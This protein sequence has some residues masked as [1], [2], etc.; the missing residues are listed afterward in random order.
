MMVFTGSGITKMV[1]RCVRCGGSV[2]IES[3][4][5]YDWVFPCK[6]RDNEYD[7]LLGHLRKHW[8]RWWFNAKNKIK[9]DWEYARTK[10]WG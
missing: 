5:K 10:I 8:D 4:P 1:G 9:E 2:S 7:S 6:C 3:G